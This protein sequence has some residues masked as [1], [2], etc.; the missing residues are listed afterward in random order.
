[1]MDII[2]GRAPPRTVADGGKIIADPLPMHALF[3]WRSRQHG[4]LL[5]AGVQIVGLRGLM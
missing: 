5:V 2:T 4:V 1:M 3:D